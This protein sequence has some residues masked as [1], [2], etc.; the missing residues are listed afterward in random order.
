MA[1]ISQARQRQIEAARRSTAQRAKISQRE[2]RDAGKRQELRKK[3]ASQAQ[4]NIDLAKAEGRTKGVAVEQAKIEAANRSQRFNEQAQKRAQIKTKGLSGASEQFKGQLKSGESQRTGVTRQGEVF[5]GAREKSLAQQKSQIPDAPAPSQAVEGETPIQRERRLRGDAE[6]RAK[7]QEDQAKAGREELST[8]SAQVGEFG[9]QL[10]QN[11]KQIQDLVNSLNTQQTGLGDS[12][13]NTFEQLAS[14]GA[15][16]E[17]TPEKLKQ[18]QEFALTTPP[19][20]LEGLIRQTLQTAVEAGAEVTGAQPAVEPDLTGAEAA[21]EPEIKPPTAPLEAPKVMPKVEPE[22]FKPDGSVVNNEYGVALQNGQYSTPSGTLIPQDA[23]TGFP[24]LTNLPPEIAAKLSSYDLFAIDVATGQ[25]TTALQNS[26]MKAFY[27]ADSLRKMS[28]QIQRD[29]QVWNDEINN[30]FDSSLR[31]VNMEKLSALQDQQLQQ[32]RV[33]LAKDTS[34][35]AMNEA[36]GKNEALMKGMIDSFGLEG[37]SAQLAVMGNLQLKYSQQLSQ[38]SRGFAIETAQISNNMS[39]IRMN[40]ANNLIDIA[41]SKNLSQD[42]ARNIL[43]ERQD[44]VSGMRLASSLEKIQERN[45]AYQDYSNAVKGT[46]AEAEQREQQAFADQQQ[47]MFDMQLE[48]IK[49]MGGIPTLAADGTVSWKTDENGEMISNLDA[50]KLFATMG[51]SEI[52]VITDEFGN[53]SIVAINPFTNETTNLGANN[54]LTNQ[55]WGG[56]DIS[57]QGQ[58]FTANGVTMNVG[59]DWSKSGQPGAASECVGFGRFWNKDLP[60]GLWSIDD[61]RAIYTQGIT[62]YDQVEV[63]DTLFING[64]STLSQSVVDSNGLGEEQVGKRTG[65]VMT[66]IGKNEDGTWNVVD[67]N[68][69]D[70]PNKSIIKTRKISPEELDRFNGNLGVFKNSN[71]PTGSLQSLNTSLVDP[72]AAFQEGIP[73]ALQIKGQVN[74]EGV[75]ILSQL[76]RGGSKTIGVKEMQQLKRRGLRG[77]F[78]PDFTKELNNTLLSGKTKALTPKDATNFN[79]PEGTTQFELEDIIQEREAQGLGNKRFQSSMGNDEKTKNFQDFINLGEQLEEAKQKF[80]AFQKAGGTLQGFG[81]FIP[82]VGLA[83]LADPNRKSEGKIQRTLDRLSEKFGGG[84]EEGLTLFRELDALVG[85][86]LAS[87]VQSISGAAVSEP[88]FQRLKQFKANVDMS[89]DQF[90][91]QLDRAI[92]DYNEVS[93]SQINKFGFES[94]EQFTSAV[95]GDPIQGGIARFGETTTATFSGSSRED[96]IALLQDNGQATSEAN[97]NFILN[98]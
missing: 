76:R 23:N 52:K 81:Q 56:T 24:N 87:F 28:E 96:A 5:T 73:E 17:M 51:K 80:E 25:Y 63:G 38:A 88:E 92:K 8:V 1:K 13:K 27:T 22:P 60:N 85:E 12:I 55:P 34:L 32:Q 41:Q 48:G 57:V 29:G 83:A 3:E 18:I 20:K 59:G 47:K 68:Y 74:E 30:T 50:R 84:A 7:F 26:E 66:L 69:D 45:T 2:V 64:G 72:N 49:Q 33:D 4:S 65:H 16:A 95:R 37:S 42:K 86:N 44:E 31:A 53:Q 15:E 61:K 67:A 40:Y 58:S 39:K 6:A 9:V 77:D 70:D 19:D 54:P 11:Q 75:V 14:E 82:D 36:H 94:R 90:I 97:I 46:A 93:Q 89:D 78:G 21:Q 71:P 91:G 43:I 79:V 98:Q 35:Q 10:Q 62:E